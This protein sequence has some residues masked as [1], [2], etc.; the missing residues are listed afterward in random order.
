MIGAVTMWNTPIFTSMYLSNK[1]RGISMN[2]NIKTKTGSLYKITDDS[3]ERLDFSE[4]SGELRTNSGSIK[5]GTTPE[6][7]KPMVMFTDSINKGYPRMIY[8]SPVVEITDNETGI[9]QKVQSKKKNNNLS[10]ESEDT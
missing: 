2:L 5:V 6:L 10:E 1:K 3:W 9:T 8:T 7:G 4:Y